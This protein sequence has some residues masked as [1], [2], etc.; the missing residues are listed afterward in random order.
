[1]EYLHREGKENEEEFD[2]VKGAAAT[3]YGAGADTVSKEI[4]IQRS[5]ISSHRLID[6]VKSFHCYV[7]DVSLP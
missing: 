4:L 2:D 6:M 1:L 3:I 5:C 7:G